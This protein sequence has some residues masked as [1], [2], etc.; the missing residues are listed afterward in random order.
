M[1]TINKDDLLDMNLELFSTSFRDMTLQMIERKMKIEKNRAELDK[2]VA[3]Y[4]VK[5]KNKTFNPEEVKSDIARAE[6][7]LE[8]SSKLLKEFE[9]LFTEYNRT[10]VDDIGF[11][12][13]DFKNIKKD[14]NFMTFNLKNLKKKFSSLLEIEKE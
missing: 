14:L 6:K 9:V 13:I 11:Y 1:K 2:I 8:T 4:D 3:K 5:D 12:E 7:L 10:F